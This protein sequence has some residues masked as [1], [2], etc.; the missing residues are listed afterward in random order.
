VAIVTYAR[1]AG[2]HY[3]RPRERTSRR[4]WTLWKAYRRG[5][6]TAGAAG[7]Q[8]AYEIAERNFVKEGKNRVI[9]CTDGDF[10][11]GVSSKEGWSR[12]SSRNGRAVFS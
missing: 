3:R 2:V 10:N 7:I 1:A 4:S 12:S 6:S 9:L 5:G 11:V 8:L